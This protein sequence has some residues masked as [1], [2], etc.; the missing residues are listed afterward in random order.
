MPPLD[1]PKRS[2][3]QILHWSLAIAIGLL[4][5]WQFH[6]PQFASNFDK[7]PGDRG[8]ARL[9]AY[10]MEHW[11]QVFQGAGDLAFARRCSTRSKEPSVT[12][13]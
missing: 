4:G 10:L 8:D 13:T 2:T 11:Y 12:P 1:A 7:F 6:I 5:L 3:V 9:V